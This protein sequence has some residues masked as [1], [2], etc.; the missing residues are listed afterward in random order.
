MAST[1]IRP[2]NE[3]DDG[4]A[5]NEVYAGLDKLSQIPTEPAI[6]RIYGHED[7]FHA[8]LLAGPSSLPKLERDSHQVAPYYKATTCD[9]SGYGDSSCSFSITTAS[10]DNGQSDTV[11]VNQLNQLNQMGHASNNNPGLRAR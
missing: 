7:T 5:A 9:D 6:R 4:G 8:L 2:S 1:S 11:S 10:I 3:D